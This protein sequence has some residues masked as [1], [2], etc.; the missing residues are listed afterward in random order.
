MPAPLTV[1]WIGRN[2]I[3]KS[4]Q[5]LINVAAKMKHVK[6]IMNLT[7]DSS[8]N[9]EMVGRISD[10]KRDQIYQ[11]CDIFCHTGG[12]P[13]PSG[14]TLI[15]AQTHG[16]PV[17]LLNRGAVAEY[18]T[19]K[20]RILIESDDIKSEE[21]LINALNIL[22]KEGCAEMGKEAKKFATETFDYRTM[23]KNYLEFYNKVAGKT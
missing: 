6:F 5:T 12:W 4:P 1:F 18:T 19:E 21:A 14:L 7:D 17:I 2:S 10:E 15:E 20:G 3:E 13:E 23:G 9:L 11:T 8:D 22:T 16:K